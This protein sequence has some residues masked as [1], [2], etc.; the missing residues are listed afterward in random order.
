MVVV[1]LLLLL[2]CRLVRCPSSSAAVA[3]ATAT[4]TAHGAHTT[5]EVVRT[6]HS[7]SDFGIF[8]LERALSGFQRLHR[9]AREL[10]GVCTRNER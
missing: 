6:T 5:D 1:L 8:N 9:A 3:A 2:L 10:D 4:T 7:A